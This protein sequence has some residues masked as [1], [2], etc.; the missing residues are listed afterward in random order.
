[1]LK[2]QKAKNKNIAKE[3]QKTSNKEEKMPD[4]QYDNGLD[5]KDSPLKPE[6]PI[7]K[8]HHRQGQ[9]YFGTFFAFLLFVFV[10]CVFCF[11]CFILLLLLRCASDNKDDITIYNIYISSL[12][13]S[14]TSCEAVK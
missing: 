13:C 1:M 8:Y 6:F 12:I 10:L 14:P 7:K 11:V 5:M 4:L 3:E 9:K 2:K